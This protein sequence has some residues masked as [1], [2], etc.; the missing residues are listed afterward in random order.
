MKKGRD[1][2]H[3]DIF[4]VRI[5][6]I[7]E[8]NRRTTD[9]M[10][11]FRIIGSASVRNIIIE[12]LIQRR[13]RD[14]FYI[15]DTKSADSLLQVYPRNVG[16]QSLFADGIDEVE[17]QTGIGINIISLP[18]LKAL[19]EAKIDIGILSEN[20]VTIRLRRL[21]IIGHTR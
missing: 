12:I 14:R 2:I 1:N 21:L 18:P 6:D 4:S 7:K 10:R 9:E 3:T 13:N 11:Q 19:F 15:K 16:L 17:H 8:I 20:S 5:G